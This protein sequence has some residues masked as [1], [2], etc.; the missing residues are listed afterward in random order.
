MTEVD[1]KSLK[2]WDFVN[3]VMNIRVQDKQ[4]ICWRVE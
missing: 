4:E 3:T 1:Y 2:G